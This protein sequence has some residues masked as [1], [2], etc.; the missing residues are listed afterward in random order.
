MA[1]LNVLAV[2]LDDVEARTNLD[3]VWFASCTVAFAFVANVKLR[4]RGVSAKDA[5]EYGNGEKLVEIRLGKNK[6]DPHTIEYRETIGGSVRFKP[7]RG[8]DRFALPFVDGEC[9][10]QWLVTT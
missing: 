2:D 4:I 8:P 5:F 3:S 9:W 6:D 7:L 10:V 1:P